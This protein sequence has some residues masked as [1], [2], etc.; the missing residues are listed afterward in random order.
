MFWRLVF[1]I[2]VALGVTLLLRYTFGIV[3]GALLAGF[4]L[5]DEKN[6][7]ARIATLVFANVFAAFISCFAGLV[8]GGL[9]LS[10]HTAVGSYWILCVPVAGVFLILAQITGSD[11]AG[12]MR[13]KGYME[14]WPNLIG[15]A[16]AVIACYYLARPWFTM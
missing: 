1:A 6:S 11:P 13:M 15:Y 3:L 10:H 12:K 5:G 14:A 7:G 4:L 2:V 8:L 16:G 9:I